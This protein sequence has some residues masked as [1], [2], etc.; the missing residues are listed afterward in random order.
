MLTVTFM[1]NNII[2]CVVAAARALS[3]T[4]NEV[5]GSLFISKG[6][7]TPSAFTSVD[8]HRRAENRTVL[9]FERVDVRQR[10]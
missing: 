1:Y 10:T 6:P 8:V 2:L 9:D 4:S 5:T 7:F 3:Q